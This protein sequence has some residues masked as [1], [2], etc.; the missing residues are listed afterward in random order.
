MGAALERRNALLKLAGGAPE[1]AI[2]RLTL[3]PLPEPLTLALRASAEEAAGQGDAAA[4]TLKRLAEQEAEPGQRVEALVRL[5]E[6]EE[7]LGRLV[8][9][10]QAFE[11]AVQVAAEGTGG[12][13]ADVVLWRAMERIS[14]GRGDT[15]RLV[16][17]ARAEAAQDPEGADLAQL[18]AAR[19]LVDMG[20]GDEAAAALEAALD[21]NPRLTVALTE[22][23]ELHL[24]AGRPAEAARW[25]LRAAD[26]SE[27]AE[28]A[29]RYRERAV[30]LLGQAG[31]LDAA[32]EVVPLLK[33]GRPGMAAV[34]GV[35]RLLRVAGRSA[36]VAYSVEAEQAGDADRGAWLWH[37]RG[38]GSDETTG[39]EDTDLI[40]AQRRALELVP[41]Y[42]AALAALELRLA[43]S[44]PAELLALG[45]AQLA[46]L[47]ERPAALAARLRLASMAETSSDAA[48]ALQFYLELRERL[49]PTSPLG[50]EVL[51]ALMGVARRTGELPRAAEAL[52]QLLARLPEGLYRTALM[53]RLAGWEE[54]HL[55]RIENA[56]TLYGRSLELESDQALAL[57]GWSRTYQALGRFDELV[58]GARARLER[59]SDVS[60][61]I[62][63]YQE[64]AYI[65]G[66]LRGDAAAAEQ[67]RQEI[68]NLDHAHHA[69]FRAL[70]QTYVRGERWLELVAIYEQMGLTATDTALAV[71]V[72]LDLV[73]L[74]ERL[75]QQEPQAID[76]DYR[77]ALYRDAHCR[78]ALRQLLGLARERRDHALLAELLGRI[79]DEETH[80]GS[81][82]G[83]GT[84]MGEALE[85]L[86]KNDLALARYRAAAESVRHVPALRALAQL[87]LRER[88]YA[89]AVWAFETAGQVLRDAQERAR[90]YLAAGVLAEEELNDR[91]H[92][93]PAY[94][95][96]LE[97]VP[98]QRDALERLQ[99]ALAHSGDWQTAARVLTER[100]G[101]ES[102]PAEIARL[103][104]ELAVLQR[105]HLSR[106]DLALQHLNEVLARD[107]A[108]LGALGALASLYYEEGR[109]AEAA[110]IFIRHGR[111]EKD[112][113][114]LKD[115]FFKLGL[116]YD[117]RLPDA[118]RA[119]VCFT[120]V[121]QYDAENQVALERLSQLATKEGE[122]RGALAATARL[123]EIETEPAKRITYLHRIATI[124][125]EGLKDVRAAHEAL[126]RAVEMDPHQLSAIG[127][128]ARFYERQGDLT[129]GRVHLDRSAQAMRQLVRQTPEDPEP[130]HA[131]FRIFNWK[132]SFDQTFMVAS[133]LKAMNKADTEEE[134]FF[135][136]FASKDGYPGQALADRSL[137]DTMFVSR[138]PP[139]FR[140]LF[141]LLDETLQ[142]AYRTDVK[143]LGVNRQERLPT[144]G[145]LARDVANRVAADLGIKDFDVYVTAASPRLLTVELTDPIALVFG[146]EVVAGLGTEELRFCVGRCLKM[147][148]SHMAVPLRLSGE[149]LGV[150]MGGI[151]RQFIPEFLPRGFD[152]AAVA[153]E[154][155]RLAKVIPRK[156]H[157]ELLPFALECA[158]PGLDFRA[159]ANDLIHTANRAG[160]LCAGNGAHSLAVLRRLKDEGQVHEL[161]R[162]V[163]SDEFAELR[164]TVGTAIG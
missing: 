60:S 128:L 147:V 6:M 157:Q 162:F 135:N 53:L 94:R 63:L 101:K 106:R 153:A 5:G 163:V 134:T 140:H 45:Q 97:S 110:D 87:A 39:T 50:L 98:G 49:P 58:A 2:E 40:E 160:V 33:E 65:D 34:R 82:A 47:G 64:L 119:M 83:F 138:I 89:E 114:V 117:E 127:E 13:V 29:L 136:R 62:T 142:R 149:E 116:I 30:R 54:L 133:L 129:S 137:D 141:R 31:D 59:A 75:A 1:R 122:W 72:F 96:V 27:D 100:L 43:G 70:E 107:P 55:G 79:V 20:Q 91:E 103:H 123:V 7:R 148:Q 23:V 77:R 118:K 10:A 4:E 17:L 69:S 93:I 36:A 159:L 86:G 131:L 11:Q 115:V 126:R 32:L 68:L 52:E 144:K 120:R 145:P 61:R 124:Q 3:A 57:P 152:A 22:L 26:R 113:A 73:R 78:P 56:A 164:R 143:R 92:A 8:E 84:R 51:Q 132:R 105:D 80:P 156:L 151:V 21:Q 18:R 16:D 15:G 19:L 121:L 76:N 155:A 154:A 150:L 71:A 44:R 46:V 109:W 37:Q 146:Q 35:E 67:D 111:I 88:A 139:G 28:L 104:F 102:D 24:A 9:A 130:Y 99:G 85:A 108:H 66:E 95:R 12:Q 38:L 112:P 14:R 90:C 74:R 25:L 161:L 42:P 48:R 41:G 158:D 81:A 125:E